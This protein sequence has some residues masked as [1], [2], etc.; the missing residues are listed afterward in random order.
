VFAVS[1]ST[2]PS[3][4]S[5]IA[6]ASLSDVP[7]ATGPIPSARRTR[8]S[9]PPSSTVVVG[10]GGVVVVVGDDCALEVVTVVVLGVPNVLVG[11]DVS[12]MVAMGCVGGVVSITVVNP[13]SRLAV[14]A[15]PEL[16][17]LVH[18]ATTNSAANALNK[19][20]MGRCTRR[21]RSDIGACWP[22]MISDANTPTCGADYGRRGG[23]LGERSQSDRALDTSVML[24]NRWSVEVTG[25]IA[26]DRGQ[27]FA[28][29]A[30]DTR[31][32]GLRTRRARLRRHC[33]RKDVIKSP[34][35]RRTNNRAAHCPR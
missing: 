31:C 10:T 22:V 2:S 24:P 20:R 17:V 13:D 35:P 32:T 9:R 26:H 16:S 23:R 25:L 34:A 33:S 8:P 18:P 21:A 11:L 28:E 7:N 30:V 19:F 1:D 14:S 3:A 4:A 15:S 27:R 29:W 5:S 6:S 12:A